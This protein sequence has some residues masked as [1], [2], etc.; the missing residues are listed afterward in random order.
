M[1][2]LPG[3]QPRARWMRLS[4]AEILKRFYFCERSLVIGCSAWLPLIGPMEA[5]T[6]LPLFS[7]QN[8]QTAQELRERIFELRYPSR[9]MAEEGADRSLIELFDE[10]RNSPSDAAFFSVLARVLLPAMRDA[11]AEFLRHSDPLADAPTHRFLR[12]ALEE[13]QHQIKTVGDWADRELAHLAHR[14]EAEAW[15]YAFNERL[16]ALGGVGTDR[17]PVGLEKQVLRGGRGYAVPSEPARDSHYR[18]TR[19]YWPDN[20][21]PTY[22]YGEGYRLQL[23]SAISHLNEVWAVE[24]GG[25]ILSSFAPVLPWEWIRDA[26]R[27]TYDESRHCRMGRDRLTAWGYHPH[28]LPLGNYIYLA[29]SGEDPIYRLGMLFFF[30]TKN[31]RHKPERVRA[32]HSIGDAT[33]EHDMDFDWADETMHAGYGKRWLQ[34]LL[35]IRGEDQSAYQ[36]I[37]DRCGELVRAVVKTAK[38]EEIAELKRLADAILTKAENRGVTASV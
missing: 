2:V 9:S 32:F 37:R 22:P 31:I 30:E 25:I 12:L 36:Q 21:D 11:Y 16:R 18:L 33:S 27:W 6:L 19:F 17:V 38:P 10:L 14:A 28:E 13:K 8:A 20:V 34:Q 15:T 3:V 4:T 5:K 24:T 26:A 29:S 23:R 1:S 35:E 7:W